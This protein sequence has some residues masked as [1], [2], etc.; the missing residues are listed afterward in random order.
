[1]KT[2]CDKN[3]LEYELLMQEDTKERFL[4]QI[5]PN[6]M[7][8][9]K[10][11]K[12]LVIIKKKREDAPVEE[13]LHEEEKHKDPIVAAP[14]PADSTP[15]L[16]SNVKLDFKSFDFPTSNFQLGAAPS[17]IEFPNLEGF[18]PKKLMMSIRDNF[19]PSHPTTT[20]PKPLPPLPSLSLPRLQSPSFSLSSISIP[21]HNIPSIDWN[22]DLILQ[23]PGTY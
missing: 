12:N 21:A 1:M 9:D 6:M 19:Q 14:A 13:E 17:K 15:S 5:K 16:F 23:P 8:F 7:P 3:G 4:R 18:E 20:T 22:R 2:E 11:S 10:L